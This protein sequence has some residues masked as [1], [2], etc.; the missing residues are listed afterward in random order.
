MKVEYIRTDKDLT[1][2]LRKHNIE[3][4]DITSSMYG[5]NKIVAVVEVPN[6]IM[7]RYIIKRF[8]GK[9]TYI[10]WYQTL[11]DIYHTAD[12]LIGEIVN[13]EIN[14]DELGSDRIKITNHH[15]IPL[16]KYYPAL[17]SITGYIY[18]LTKQKGN[19]DNGLYNTACRMDKVLVHYTYGNTPMNLYEYLHDKVAHGLSKEAFDGIKAKLGILGVTYISVDVNTIMSIDSKQDLKIYT[20]QPDISTK[21]NTMKPGMITKKQYDPMKCRGIIRNYRIEDIPKSAFDKY[22]YRDIQ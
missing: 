12:T 15:C 10:S 4:Y 17:G 3:A 16:K 13:L 6:D 8:D 20:M 1:V 18:S 5:Y 11:I 9:M 22:L 7:C 14:N 2:E 21:Y 19:I